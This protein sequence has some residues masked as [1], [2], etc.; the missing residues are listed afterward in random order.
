MRRTNS[1]ELSRVNNEQASE[2]G[3]SE[4]YQLTNLHLGRI[5]T[6]IEVCL[7]PLPQAIHQIHV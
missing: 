1:S 5:F 4:M 3:A 7:A 6:S 2:E